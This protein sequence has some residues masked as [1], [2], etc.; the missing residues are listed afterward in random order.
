MLPKSLH[1]VGMLI[2][3]ARDQITH[4]SARLRGGFLVQESIK[5]IDKSVEEIKYLLA[6]AKQI[7]FLQEYRKDE[8][9]TCCPRN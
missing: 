3:S 7:Q 9:N 6:E 1:S 8:S 4:H 2:L 5:E